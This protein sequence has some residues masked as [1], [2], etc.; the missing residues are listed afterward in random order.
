MAEGFWPGG[1]EPATAAVRFAVAEG[2]VVLESASPGASIAFSIDR[3]PWRIYAEP[4]ALAPG[5]GM[6][7]RAVRY[8]WSESEVTG[9]TVPWRLRSGPH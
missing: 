3:A 5:T 2:R 6:R 7:A 8:G 9:W 1:E 4:L